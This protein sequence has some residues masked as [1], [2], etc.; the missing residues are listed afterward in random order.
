MLGRA[1]L[2][3]HGWKLEVMRGMDEV[4]WR[5]YLEKWQRIYWILVCWFDST[6]T[7]AD[8]RHRGVGT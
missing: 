6:R 5:S 2:L 8:G 7:D 4:E 1:I 3:P